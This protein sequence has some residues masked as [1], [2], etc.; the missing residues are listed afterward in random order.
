[1]RALAAAGE[2]GWSGAA[3]TIRE[4]RPTMP[5]AATLFWN[6]LADDEF[7]RYERR[8]RFIDH[9]AAVLTHRQAEVLG[10]V[11]EECWD[12]GHCTLPIDALAYEAVV[13]RWAVH[14]ALHAARTLRLIEM[15][16]NVIRIVSPEW[17]AL[18]REQEGR[19]VAG[20]DPHHDP[21]R[22]E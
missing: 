3:A 12:H 21:V 5:A 6:A 22:I 14:S 8:Q 19:A 13:S 16:E 15:R 4:E 10:V 11:G 1:M 9:F 20:T 17:Q 2:V 18:L 7:G